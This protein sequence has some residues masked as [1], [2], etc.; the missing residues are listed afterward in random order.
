M[1]ESQKETIERL[2]KELEDTRERISG[3]MSAVDEA[4]HETN[5]YKAMQQELKNLRTIVNSEVMSI[6]RQVKMDERRQAYVEKILADNKALC[7]KHGVEYWEGIAQ[8]DRY[9][10]R[11]IREME[12]EITD[13]KALVKAKDIVIEHFKKILSGKDAE[14]PQMRKPGRPTIDEEQKKRIRKLRR[15]GWTLRQIQEAEG[16]SLGIISK[17]C[18]GM[19]RIN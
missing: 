16:I 19:K 10:F 4:Y 3:L 13:L 9:A 2:S 18:K 6:E 5:E 12:Q 7:K 15:D 11:D 14:P 17:I 8:Q 1:R